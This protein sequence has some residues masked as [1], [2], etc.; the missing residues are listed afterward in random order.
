MKFKKLIV[1]IVSV[2]IVS[3]WIN[4]KVEAEENLARQKSNLIEGIKNESNLLEE[5]KI[6]M[7]KPCI[8]IITSEYG[9]REINSATA[10]KNHK[11]I[12]IGASKGA[13]ILAA[14]T[15]VVLKANIVGNYGK[16]IIIQNGE[17]K[18][19]YAHCSK[20][21][22]SEGENVV[23]GQKIAEVG[24]TG[25]ATGNHLHFEVIIKGENVNP[26]DVIDW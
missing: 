14:H 8:G 22:V 1:L 3:F 18:T 15:G 7:L 9:Y 19:L 2:C 26:K 4:N 23:T 12:D 16:C 17:Y 5:N 10:S 21:L 24:S 6:K 11:G 20:L 25:N 13:D